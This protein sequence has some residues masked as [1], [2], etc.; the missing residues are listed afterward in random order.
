MYNGL[1]IFLFKVVKSL[2][3]NLSH[4][5]DLEEI[6]EC[7]ERQ[8]TTWLNAIDGVPLFSAISNFIYKP[9][10]ISSQI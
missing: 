1:N 8:T 2:Q 7:K 6:K 9:F 5:I 10:L 4:E 3:K